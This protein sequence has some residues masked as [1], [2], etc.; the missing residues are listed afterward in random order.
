M[1]FWNRRYLPRDLERCFDDLTRTL[2]KVV[3]PHTDKYNCIAYAAGDKSRWWWPDPY[4]QYYWPPKAVREQTVEAF[5]GM[6]R[7]F[8]YT[9]SVN[10]ESCISSERVAIYY[11][12][13]GSPP[14]TWAGMPTHAARQMINRRWRSKLGE[15]HMIE[16]STLECLN[17]RFPAYGEP[18]AILARRRFWLLRFLGKF[19]K[20]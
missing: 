12:P 14:D 7:L 1:A 18:I 17:G 5:D 9:D 15:W 11:D 3:S 20:K 8:E 19:C 16:H 10:S 2:Y 6:F 4:G 13:V